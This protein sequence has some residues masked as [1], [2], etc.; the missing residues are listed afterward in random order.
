[1]ASYHGVEKPK[2]HNKTIILLC[3]KTVEALIPFPNE[4]VFSIESNWIPLRCTLG[5]LDSASSSSFSNLS[6]FCVSPCYWIVKRERQMLLVLRSYTHI[7]RRVKRQQ[8]D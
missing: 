1:M 3:G 5:V 7:S 6:R 4:D 8:I 2:I